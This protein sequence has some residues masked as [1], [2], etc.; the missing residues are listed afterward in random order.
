MNKK[1]RAEYQAAIDRCETL[2]ALRWTDPVERDVPAPTPDSA[3]G[4]YS[5]GWDYNAHSKLVWLGW[6]G[7]VSHGDGPAPSGGLYRSGRQNSRSLF[8]TKALALKAMRNEI[9][10]MAAENLREVDRRIALETASKL[11]ESKD[12]R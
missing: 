2:A 1:E 10:R 12:D 3:S 9:E 6:S 5:E 7:P 11:L 4:T 8:S